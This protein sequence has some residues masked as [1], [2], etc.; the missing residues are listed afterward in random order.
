MSSRPIDRSLLFVPGNRPER[1][2]KALAAGADAVIV[3]LEDAVPPVEKCAARDSVAGWMDAAHPV[4]LRINDSNSSWFRDDL[5]LCTRPGIAGIMLAKAEARE[6]LE[7]LAA[8]APATPLLP[9]IETAAGFAN[10]E[11]LA[12]A[13]GVQRLVFGNIDLQLD[14]GIAGNGE[15]LNYFRSSLVLISRLAGI[16]P[17]IDGVCTAFDDVDA[18][19]A[20]AL[21]GR[22]FGFGGKLCIHPKQVAGVNA[23]YRPDADEIAWA[24]RVLAVAATAHGAAVALEGKMVDRPVIRRAEQILMEARRQPIS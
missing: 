20:E 24:E 19:R 18:L 2:N 11:T 13:P 4:V 23:A 21:R 1:F 22:R 17:P 8:L 5:G 7:A 14:L 12:R 3:D 15:E 6:E 10:A 16:A 9:L